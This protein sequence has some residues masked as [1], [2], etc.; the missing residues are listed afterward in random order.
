[1][2][3]LPADLEGCHRKQRSRSLLCPHKA[4]SQ[5]DPS[6]RRLVV[7]QLQH[8]VKNRNKQGKLVGTAWLSKQLQRLLYI[9]SG[10]SCKSTVTQ[11]AEKQKQQTIRNT[12]T[13]MQ[14]T[15]P[16]RM[17]HDKYHG[18]T[19]GAFNH[20]MIVDLYDSSTETRRTRHIDTHMYTVYDT[21]HTKTQALNGGIMS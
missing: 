6:Q 17:W 5:D 14:H 13:E 8:T 18:P 9:C 16:A 21:K 19:R 15:P 10:V 12:S 20:I 7:E 4:W 1:M 11:R 2:F 3:I